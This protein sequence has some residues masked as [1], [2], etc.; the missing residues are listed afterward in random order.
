MYT[1]HAI[2]RCKQRSIS[3]EVVDALLSYGEV[4]RHA[5]ADI[6]YLTKAARQRA[7]AA[8]GE[9]YRR[10]EKSLNSYLVLADNGQ[11]ITAGRRYRSLKF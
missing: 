10:V 4:K 2:A 3:A 5:G 6:Y 1:A 9:G 8:L 11:M 7:A